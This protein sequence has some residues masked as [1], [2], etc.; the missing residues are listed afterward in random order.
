ML[1]K[2]N[3]DDEASAKF[4]MQ[5]YVDASAPVLQYIERLFYSRDLF[6]LISGEIENL[7]MLGLREKVTALTL[8]SKSAFCFKASTINSLLAPADETRKKTTSWTAISLREANLVPFILCNVSGFS[9]SHPTANT[10]AGCLGGGWLSIKTG[11][12][13]LVQLTSKSMYAV[14]AI[15]P[16]V[17]GVEKV[18]A[19]NCVFALRFSIALEIQWPQHAC[20]S[21][22]DEL[23]EA[24][25][26]L[27]CFADLTY[28]TVCACLQT[29]HKIEMD[30]RDGKFEPQPMMGVPPVQHMS[31]PY[32]HV[33]APKRS[34]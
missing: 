29:Q 27:N 16:A 21:G 7:S 18:S 28:C 13:N 14:R 2:L 8:L 20:L 15:C 5:S 31:H 4:H 22:N 26:R 24:S 30:K 11:F 19:L 23:Q 1:T 3:E 17:V 9:R 12:K 33:A 34:L 6:H 32:M 25:Q 10:I